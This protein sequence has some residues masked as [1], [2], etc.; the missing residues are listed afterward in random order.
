MLVFNAVK[1]VK[2]SKVPATIQAT[3]TIII[4]W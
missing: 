2:T 3:S 1:Q 4:P